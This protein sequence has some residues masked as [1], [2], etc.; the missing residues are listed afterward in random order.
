VRV[1]A[2]AESTLTAIKAYN[3]LAEALK[4]LPHLPLQVKTVQHASPGA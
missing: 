3:Q 4:D 2:N 1:T